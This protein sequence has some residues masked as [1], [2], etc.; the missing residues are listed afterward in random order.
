[1]LPLDQLE[2]ARLYGSTGNP[3]E[4]IFTVALSAFFEWSWET[5]CVC[6]AVHKEPPFLLS[7]TGTFKP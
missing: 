3:K 4:R 5:L 6:G 7:G 2:N 1:M